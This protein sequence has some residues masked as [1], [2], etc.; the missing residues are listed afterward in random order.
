MSYKNIVLFDYPIA[1]YP[2][3]EII[4]DAAAEDFTD[5]LSQFSTYQDV[6]DNVDTYDDLFAT[7]AI[8][9]SG[10]GNNGFY[11]NFVR[12]DIFPLISNGRTGTIIDDTQYL[13]LPITKDYSGSTANGGFANKYTSDNDFTLEI[14]VSSNISTSNTTTLFAD[15]TE[16]IGI[17]WEKGN[18]VFKLDSE[19]LD[20]TA[21]ESGRSMHIVC[22]YSVSSMA[23]Y[24]NGVFAASKEL[25][26]FTFTNES[27]LLQIGP[28]SHVSDKFIVDA[29]AVY[30]YALSIDQ[31]RSHFNY[32][33]T[34][35]P[36]QIVEPDDGQLFLTSDNNILKPIVFRYPVDK[37]WSEFYDVNL[38]HD[39][40]ENYISV[41][42][43]DTVT[44]K[45]FTIYDQFSI[46]NNAEL[47]SSKVEWYGTAGV[48]IETSTDGVTYTACQ[49][50]RIIPQYKRG[51]LSNT[52]FLYV[53]I[54]L[55][56]T[57]AS[58]YLPKL[59]N[60]NFYFYNTKRIYAVNGGD[61]IDSMEPLAGTVDDSV[62]DYDLSSLAYPILS[63]KI[64]NGIRPYD[65]G[66][67]I[68]TLDNIYSVE[69]MFTP[70]STAAN[71]LAF[72]GSS[73]Y[74]AWNGSGVISKNNI[75][76][77]YVNGINRSSATNI[78]S[79]LTAGEI[80]HIVL[81]FSS[82]V[83]S[84]IWFNV[85]VLSNTWTDAGPRNLYSYIA[86][87]KTQISQ[88]TAEN[89]YNLYTA[90]TITT[91]TVPSMTV[92]ESAVNVYNKDWRIVKSI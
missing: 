21:E 67:F 86:T 92:T 34:V 42:P 56:T 23:I 4:S 33:N 43:T 84:K 18:I 74:F 70:I 72:S 75:S 41:I 3:D 83:T 53:K 49:N 81:V 32:A 8:D 80:H 69:M 40:A 54:T 87:Y 76:A 48:T 57:D 20:Y 62:W 1:Y 77:I 17:F 16:N 60:L 79:F 44:A 36:L 13:I 85:K 11:L 59:Y 90:K 45:T 61:F 5:L 47:M 88:A 12:Q 68:D 66:F 27:V 19:R 52:S 10:C 2:L 9:L 58:K 64:D 31:I 24:V 82:T 30:R 6:L 29:P 89:H 63:R 65:P 46:P 28:T 91:A 22:T 38:Y 73:T 55:T 37:Q 35:S 7:N 15:P 71:Y 50:G 26:E 78:S 39:Q 14:W 25:N 51:S